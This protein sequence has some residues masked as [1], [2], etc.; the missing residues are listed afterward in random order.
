MTYERMPMSAAEGWIF[1]VGHRHVACTHANQI[2]FEVGDGS[3]PVCPDCKEDTLERKPTLS[4]VC[5][6]GSV[7]SP[8]PDTANV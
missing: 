1:H 6:C 3:L 8:R 7:F 4:I 5:E 2:E